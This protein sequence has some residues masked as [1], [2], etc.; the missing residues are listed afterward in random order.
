M[1]CKGRLGKPPLHEA[2]TEL[3]PAPGKVITQPQDLSEKLT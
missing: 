2:S 3:S 1:A